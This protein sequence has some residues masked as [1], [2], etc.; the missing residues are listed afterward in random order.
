MDGLWVVLVVVYVVFSFISEAAKKQRGAAGEEARRRARVAARERAERLA[1][2]RAA[3]PARGPDHGTS[4][5]QVEAR[6]LEELLRGLGGALGLPD[7]P[8]VVSV[9]APAEADQPEEAYSL[10]GVSLE[11]EPR[12]A[13]PVRVARVER[14]EDESAS[15]LVQ[16]RIDAAAVRSG[17]L[18]PSDHA[19]FHRRLAIQSAPVQVERSAS[20]PTLRAGTREDLRRAVVWREILGPPV[21]LREG[22]PV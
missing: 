13:A 15:A 14:T 3:P 17:A 6:R 4:P 18:G 20:R 5:T 7:E 16:R 21:A 11:G 12:E 10:E 9:P 8:V 2:T 1:R 19:A 22:D